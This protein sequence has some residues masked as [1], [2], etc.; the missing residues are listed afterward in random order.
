MVKNSLANAEDWVPSLDR[1]DPLKKEM[2]TQFS[3][4]A[5]R[6][7]WTEETGGLQSTGLQRVGHD[8]VTE[9]THTHTH[10]H[11]HA[12]LVACSSDAQ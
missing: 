9:H 8:C 12:P 7:L 2:A 6:I 10:T 1:E 4:P 5:W 11:T 3:I